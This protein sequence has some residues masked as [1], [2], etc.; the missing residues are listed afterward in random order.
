MT[1]ERVPEMQA[2]YGRDVVYLIG[3]ALI[4]ERETLVEACKRLC[5]TVR[6]G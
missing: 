6:A 4:R 5:E 2:A 1:F 3:G